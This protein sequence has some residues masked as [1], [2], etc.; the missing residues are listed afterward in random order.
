VALL[1]R[2][3]L[4]VGKLL[5]H[6]AAAGGGATAITWDSGAVGA[7]YSLVTATDAEFQGGFATFDWYNVRSTS[8]KTSGKWYGEIE[9]YAC[10]GSG[11][12]ENLTSRGLAASTMG[13]TDNPAFASAASAQYG[14][15]G[16]GLN[17]GSNFTDVAGA[18]NTAVNVVGDVWMFALDFTADKA[19][20]GLNGSWLLSG[21]PGAGTNEWLTGISGKTMHLAGW[22]S[23][24]SFAGDHRIRNDA[25]AAPS[26]FSLWGD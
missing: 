3:P 4:V 7:A 17:V 21:N 23:H 15:G 11:L 6:S 5:N 24:S 9:L 12:A 13:T 22:G 2:P 1:T 20:I 25:Y 10:P 14:Y 8:G 26:G 16:D 19:W 18:F